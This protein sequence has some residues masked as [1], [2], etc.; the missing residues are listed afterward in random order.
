MHVSAAGPVNC[1]YLLHT[2]EG[3]GIQLLTALPQGPMGS[4]CPH[5]DCL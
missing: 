1:S 3:L 5:E 4:L 2:H